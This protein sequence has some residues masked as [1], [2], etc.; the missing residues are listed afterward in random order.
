MKQFS[1]LDSPISSLKGWMFHSVWLQTF[2]TVEARKVVLGKSRAIGGPRCTAV[3][4]T[5]VH[6]TSL[7][8]EGIKNNQHL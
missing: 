5:G 4:L 2:T 1:E 6:L 8:D 7:V 3:D